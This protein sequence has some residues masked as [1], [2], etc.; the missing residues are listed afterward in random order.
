MR[1]WAQRAETACPRSPGCCVAGPTFAPSLWLHSSTQDR[2]W[3]R[4]KACFCYRP[5]KARPADWSL[6]PTVVYLSMPSP[7]PSPHA[8]H[9]PARADRQPFPQNHFLLPHHCPDGSPC[10]GCPHRWVCLSPTQMPPPPGSLL[11][12]QLEGVTPLAPD[13]P[14]SPGTQERQ[15]LFVAVT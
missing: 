10:W 8:P 5:D 9:N 7:L 3:T 4:S 12:P 13:L 6:W 1:K 14:L 11:D 15:A 2:Q